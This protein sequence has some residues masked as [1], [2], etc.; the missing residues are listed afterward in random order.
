MPVAAPTFW[1]LLEQSRLL[2]PEQVRQLGIDFSA[3]GVPSDPHDATGLAQWLVSRN[4]I[5]KYQ[6]TILLAGRSGPFLYGDY[7]VYDRIEKRRLTG[8]FRAVHRPTGHPVTLQFLTGPV[9]SDPRLWAHGANL[10][11][12]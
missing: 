9:V 6:S 10:A 4:V 12:A 11:L 3:A 7:S 5:S 8:W 2:T 1:N